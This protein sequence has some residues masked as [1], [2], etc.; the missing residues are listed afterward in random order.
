M[1]ECC[2]CTISGHGLEPILTGGWYK[3][4]HVRSLMPGNHPC[5]A[6][7]LICHYHEKLLTCLGLAAL[8]VA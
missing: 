4:A 3:P 7:A 8:A 1:K 6:L 2:N 5:Y